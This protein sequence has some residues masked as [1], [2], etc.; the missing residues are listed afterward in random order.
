MRL[1]TL[2]PTLTRVGVVVIAMVVLSFAI[3]EM[4]APDTYW[5]G[6]AVGYLVGALTAG[7]TGFWY[8]KKSPWGSE[9]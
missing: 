3:V 8:Y 5:R 6:A 4:T 1:H 7:Y 9:R 2:V